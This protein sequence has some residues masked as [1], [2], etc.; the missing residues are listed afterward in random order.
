MINL[1]PPSYKEEIT[2]EENQ[3]LVLILGTLFLIFLISLIL[4]LF[5][6]KIYIQGQVELLESLVSLE[7]KKIQ[8]AGT[9][10]LR[11]KITLTN[12]EI[13]KLESFYK[14]QINLTEI[15]EKI[16]QTMPAK[17][18]LTG[19]SWQKKTYQ[20]ALSGF[21]P[22][23]EILFDFKN[24]LEGKKEFSE[25]YFPSANWIKPTDIDF[26]VSFKIEPA[27]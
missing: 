7:E 23:R 12:Q 18:Y 17:I 19:F 22:S 26:Q 14:N 20:V 2:K 13:S 15:L 21:S 1:L 9:Q 3:R 6:V 24:N 16:F 10:D 4:I 25:I 8:T 27:K 11:E 5:S